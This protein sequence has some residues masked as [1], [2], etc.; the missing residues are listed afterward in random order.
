M[1]VSVIR[2]IQQSPPKQELN[3]KKE[4]IINSEN[5]ELVEKLIEKNKDLFATSDMQL[6][7]QTPYK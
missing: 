1:L 5:R 2:D 7:V 3:L 6:G 4:L